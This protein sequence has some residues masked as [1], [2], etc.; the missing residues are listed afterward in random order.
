MKKRLI[1][2]IVIF[3]LSCINVLADDFNYSFIRG[4]ANK[5]HRFSPAIKKIHL[6]NI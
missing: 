6:E 4:E 2:S 3:P 5:F 1:L